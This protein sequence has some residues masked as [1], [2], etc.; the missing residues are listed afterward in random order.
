VFLKQKHIV[1]IS[2]CVCVC[3]RWCPVGLVR[4]L[5]VSGAQTQHHR[6]QRASSHRSP[7]RLLRTRFLCPLD[8]LRNH[9]AF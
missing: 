5:L 6:V 8:P 1:V 3:V 4:A 7:L 9:A 2:P